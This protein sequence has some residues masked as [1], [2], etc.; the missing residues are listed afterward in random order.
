MRT[1]RPLALALALFLALL[2][3]PAAR[4]HFDVTSG[5][6][7]Q[8][9]P[10]G[11]A[12]QIQFDQWWFHGQTPMVGIG[13]PSLREHYRDGASHYEYLRSNTWTRSDPLGTFSTAWMAPMAPGMAWAIV[14]NALMN[15]GLS[16]GTWAV[17]AAGTGFLVA[18]ENWDSVMM[19]VQNT[20]AN[21]DNWIG[22]AANAG[23]GTGPPPERPLSEL[24]RLTDG[25][26]IRLQQAGHRIHELKAA[27]GNFDLYKDT[28]GWVYRG[29]ANGV[30]NGECLWVSLQHGGP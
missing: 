29:L 30:G 23:H 18:T 12:Q 24:R 27:G 15:A 10:I 14:E 22:D 1:A 9:D 11:M 17:G 6:W 25:D 3:S 5:R 4:A 20:D 7:L 26:I 8:P 16:A 19:A 21:W 28:A 2:C 13:G